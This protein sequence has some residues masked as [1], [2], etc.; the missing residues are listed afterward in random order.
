M[1]LLGF[2]NSQT[3]EIPEPPYLKIF[4]DLNKKGIFESLFVF[5]Q[6]L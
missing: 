2:G 6:N 1:A 4:Y 5:E 3:D